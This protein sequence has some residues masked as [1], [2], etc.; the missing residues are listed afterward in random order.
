MA[1][2]AS[3]TARESG[4]YRCQNCGTIISIERGLPIPLCS[5][6]GFDTFALCNPRF[7]S[8]EQAANERARTREN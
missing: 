7:A 6:C 3:E 4:D 5:N 2:K 1:E 8:T